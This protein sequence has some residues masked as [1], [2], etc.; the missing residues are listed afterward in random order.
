MYYAYSYVTIHAQMLPSTYRCRGDYNSQPS[1][2]IHTKL[3]IADQSR[4]CSAIQ[5]IRNFYE[6]VMKFLYQLIYCEQPT[7]CTCGLTN[8][9]QALK[10]YKITP[11][12]ALLLGHY[13]KK[14][15]KIK[16][17]YH[18]PQQQFIIGINR[19]FCQNS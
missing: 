14:T 13:A 9:R 7:I 19:K 2:K 11:E 10:H 16:T 12:M 18:E 6:L 15:V 4:E 3:E 5:P 8:V 1:A 17:T